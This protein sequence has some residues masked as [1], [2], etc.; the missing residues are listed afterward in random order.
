MLSDWTS[1]KLS[2]GKDLIHV[3]YSYYVCIFAMHAL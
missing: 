2:F 3:D 1:L